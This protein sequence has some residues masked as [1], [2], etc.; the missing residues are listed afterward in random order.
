MSVLMHNV[1]ALFSPLFFA[2]N[3]KKS[4]SIKSLILYI[5]V[6][7]MLPFALGTKSN[8]D[9]GDV[10]V[11]IYILVMITLFVFYV[12]SYRF[13]F[14]DV[15]AKFFYYFLFLISLTSFSTF[16]MGSAQ[17]KRVGMYSLMIMLVPIVKSIEDNYSNKKLLRLI[18]FVVLILPTLLF[19]SSLGML[20]T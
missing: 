14:N 1:S 7:V 12:F 11:E 9:T 2:I 4:I 19:S 10:G 20:L 13:V 6:I 16:L 17:S 3:N 18:V 5:S 8:N 15:A